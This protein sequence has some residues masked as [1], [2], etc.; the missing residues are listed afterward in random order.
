MDVQD[1]F[2]GDGILH[3]ML[4]HSPHSFTCFKELCFSYIGVAAAVGQPLNIPVIVR[5]LAQDMYR[6]GM[7]PDGLFRPG[8]ELMVYLDGNLSSNGLDDPALGLELFHLPWWTRANPPTSN[9]SSYLSSATL[10]HALHVYRQQLEAAAIPFSLPHS[11]HSLGDELNKPAYTWHSSVNDNLPNVS[12]NCT[13]CRLYRSVALGIMDQVRDTFNMVHACEMAN[14]AEKDIAIRRA[15]GFNELFEAALKK[16][17]SPGEDE[18]GS[19][20]GLGGPLE[21]LKRWT[22][23]LAMQ[24][25]ATKWTWGVD[26]DEDDLRDL[27]RGADRPLEDIHSGYDRDLPTITLE[28]DTSD[29]VHLE[30]PSDRDL[31]FDTVSESITSI[32]D[33]LPHAIP[34]YLVSLINPS[35]VVDLEADPVI[36][37]FTKKARVKVTKGKKLLMQD[38]V[39]QP[40]SYFDFGSEFVPQTALIPHRPWL[41]HRLP[42]ILPPTNLFRVSTDQVIS[43]D[44][45]SEDKLPAPDS[46][47]I[48]GHIDI[49]D[50]DDIPN[51]LIILDSDS[52]PSD[53][54]YFPALDDDDAMDV[55]NSDESTSPQGVRIIVTTD[56]DSDDIPDHI[57]LSS[58]SAN[59]TTPAVGG[60]GNENRGRF[61]AASFA[62]YTDEFLD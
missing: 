61:T 56:S 32:P 50:S 33:L 60:L 40:D 1:S 10:K 38:E 48:P 6:V 55:V 41:A 18:A 44:T 17:C 5:S 59:A 25:G 8:L 26:L 53:Q 35:E 62:H 47:D 11:I 57:I 28:S 16:E 29:P 21:E 52:R 2:S 36:E 13:R 27:I 15:S 58:E 4:F 31:R 51:H 42:F 30:D 24:S 7:I 20:S 46:D 12:N 54:I 39:D 14:Q 37:A 19:G 49:P 9:P 22:K 3:Y 23:K 43:S 34:A 45:D